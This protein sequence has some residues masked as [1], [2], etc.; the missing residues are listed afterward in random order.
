[1]LAVVFGRP[2]RLYVLETTASHSGA[3]VYAFDGDTGSVLGHAE[4]FADASSLTLSG[5]GSTA[6]VTNSGTSTTVAMVRLD[7]TTDTPRV[8]AQTTAPAPLKPSPSAG[9]ATNEDGSLVFT[10]GGQVWSGDLSRVV[11]TLPV[12]VPTSPSHRPRT[13]W[14]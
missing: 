9:I 6:Y 8:T 13:D 12:G 14:W 2:G 3:T 10:S 1:V 4:V 5:D 7:V 11:A